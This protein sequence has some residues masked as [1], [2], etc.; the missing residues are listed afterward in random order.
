MTQQILVALQ[1]LLATENVA[2][3]IDAVHY[4]VKARG[5]MDVNSRTQTTSLGGVFKSDER[6][7][8]EFLAN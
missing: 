8:F 4:C 5:V 7:R 6:T 3:T 2:I 1:T